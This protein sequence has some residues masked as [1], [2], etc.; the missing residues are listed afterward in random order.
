M[1]RL[2]RL[3]DALNI[4]LERVPLVVTSTPLVLPS[5][6]NERGHSM[7]KAKR[8]A[9]HRLVG[10]TLGRR[11]SRDWTLHE[12]SLVVLLTRIAPR[13]L[14]DDNA[15]T[16]LKSVRDG[17]AEALGVDDRDERVVWL[18]DQRQGKPAVELT[19]WVRP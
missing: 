14:D 15:A 2:L 12:L 3:R 19:V 5:R 17:V 10:K 7:A 13:E 9:A 18:V 6:A 16:A 11:C 1:K 4:A 8:N